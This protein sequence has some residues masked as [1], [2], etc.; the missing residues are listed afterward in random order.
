MKGRTTNKMPKPAVLSGATSN[1]VKEARSKADGFKR[2]GAMKDVG[3][4]FGSA[5]KK[6]LDKRA[7]GGKVMSAAANVPGVPS[8]SVDKSNN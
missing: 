6:R 7:R 2:G 4:V 1:V 8:A 5:G 3:N